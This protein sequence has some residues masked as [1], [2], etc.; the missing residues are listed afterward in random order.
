MTSGAA[1]QYAREVA[2][3]YLGDRAK[4]TTQK[5]SHVLTDAEAGR[6]EGLYRNVARGTTVT[7]VREQ[8]GVRLERGPALL[9]MS[10]SRF[11]QARGA[12]SPSTVTSADETWEF[13]GRGG[14]RLTDEFGTIDTYERVPHAT[15]TGDE[16]KALTGSYTSD[17]AETTFIA[18][19][20]GGSLVLKQRP[21]H[22]VKLTPVYTDAFSGGSLGM[23]IFRRDA[24][25]QVASFSIVQDRVWD[26]R[27]VRQPQ[28]T[29]TR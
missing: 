8:G 6:I 5:A 23:V 12:S 15:P 11:V 16:L 3:V 10:S 26:L 21:D 24:G 22:I 4:A 17:E 7:I 19:L 27:F 20:D 9:A 14:A 2:D 13:D 28:T 25:G 1:T 29:S 18:A